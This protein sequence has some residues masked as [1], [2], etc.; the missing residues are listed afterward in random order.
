MLLQCMGEC[1]AFDLYNI[2]RET[3]KTDKYLHGRAIGRDIFSFM[4]N[5]RV[6]RN[7]SRVR[8]RALCDHAECHMKNVHDA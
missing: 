4:E 8:P 3:V 7:G 2:L 5:L 6:E 1:S